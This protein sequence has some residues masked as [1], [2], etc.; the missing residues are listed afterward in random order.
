MSISTSDP[1]GRWKLWAKWLALITVGYPVLYLSLVLR[2]VLSGAEWFLF[3]FIIVMLAKYPPVKQ[4]FDL[5]IDGYPV[6]IML[7]MNILGRIWI[8][9]KSG[10]VQGKSCI[11]KSYGVPIW[12]DHKINLNGK[13]FS[14][15]IYAKRFPDGYMISNYGRG[16][17][18][19]VTYNAFCF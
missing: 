8:N 4:R 19:E 14:L 5:V 2:P 12:L 3:P 18:M 16:F 9:W 6:R 11:G 7:Y 1:S 10:A 15:R 13:Q 17:D